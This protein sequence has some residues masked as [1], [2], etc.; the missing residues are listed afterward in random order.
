[1]IV[2]MRRTI[3]DDEG[4]SAG[5]N[6]GSHKEK[7]P[8][9]ALLWVTQPPSKDDSPKFKE[10]RESDASCFQTTSALTSTGWQSL[11]TEDHTKKTVW[12]LLF[13]RSF[14]VQRRA[15][16]KCKENDQRRQPG[17][18]G[19]NEGTGNKLMV[20]E[21]HKYTRASS[22]GTGSKP[23]VPDEEKLF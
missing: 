15:L 17:T 4:P 22:E 18:R 11:D 13:L 20:P 14:I 1:M 23:G 10:T 16:K 21:S 8:K 5:F 12:Y 3:D 19:S 6:H 7:K 2:M 9:S